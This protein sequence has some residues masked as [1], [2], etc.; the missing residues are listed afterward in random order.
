LRTLEIF[1][2]H[3]ASR[4]SKGWRTVGLAAMIAGP[5]RSRLE[6]SSQLGVKASHRDVIA[7]N[8]SYALREPTEGYGLQFTG[9][10][11]ALSIKTLSYG[12][13]LLMKKGHS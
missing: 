2:E 9:K 10:N 11:E 3:I 8:G 1:K 7:A 5:K 12:M 6:A 13:K 4:W